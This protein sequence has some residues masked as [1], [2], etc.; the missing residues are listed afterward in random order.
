MPVNWAA[1]IIAFGVAVIV[2]AFMEPRIG[3]ARPHWSVRKRRVAAASLLPALILLLTIAGLLWLLVT[4]PGEGENMQ[5]LALAVTAAVGLL[6]AVLT[7]AAGWLGA[8]AA[9]KRGE[10]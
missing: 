3:T 10:P 1:F 6:F 7:L 4:G 5:D 8:S 2:G 9:G